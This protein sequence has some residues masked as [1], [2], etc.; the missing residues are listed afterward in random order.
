MKNYFQQFDNW[1]LVVVSFH[2]YG[3]IK[4]SE[5]L[6]LSAILLTNICVLIFNF[7]L[8]IVVSPV[9]M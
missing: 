7:S 6:F 2:K 1:L 9:I 8:P 4:L 5:I 3:R